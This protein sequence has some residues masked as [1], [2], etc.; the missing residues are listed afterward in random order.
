M[1]DWSRVPLNNGRESGAKTGTAGIQGDPNGNDSD[2][3]MVGYTPQVSAAV[4]VGSGKTEPIY[5]ANH[6]PEYGADLPGH[7]WRDFM[8]SYLAGKPALPLPTKQLIGNGADASSSA[9]STAPTTTAATTSA[10]PSS[11]TAPTSSAPVSSSAPPSS[12]TPSCTP[13]G[14]LI[15]GICVTK[16]SSAP[17]PS[18]LRRPAHGDTGAHHLAGSSGSLG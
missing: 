9:S 17:P 3:W 4:W 15:G 8:N 14:I 13:P 11:S 12:A 2:A 6:L 16:S 18:T 7:I 5:N 1:A 10:A